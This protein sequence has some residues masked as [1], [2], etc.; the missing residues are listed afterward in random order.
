MVKPNPE[1]LWEQYIHIPVLLQEVIQHIQPR[2]GGIYLDCTV[3]LGGHASAILENSS[4]DGRLIGID[5]DKDAIAIAQKNLSRFQNRVIL[6]HGNF[7][8]LDKILEELDISSVDGILM[9]LGVSSLQLE[10]PHRGFSFLKSG[11][12]DMRMDGNC[13]YSVQTFPLTKGGRGV[14]RKSLEGE[15]IHK[16]NSHFDKANHKPTYPANPSPSLRS[17][18]RA[19]RVNGKVPILGIPQSGKAKWQEG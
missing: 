17:G 6:I 15:A 11:P 10:T 14:V 3:G 2:S 5:L 8:N 7:V 4:P 9:D 1:T 12:L 18:S 16:T 13:P 19:G